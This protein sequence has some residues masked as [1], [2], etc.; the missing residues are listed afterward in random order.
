MSNHT[1]GERTDAYG[2]CRAFDSAAL[3]SSQRSRPEG[4]R[5]G[6]GFGQCG[7]CTVII[8]GAAV[9][10]CITPCSGVK[11]EITTLEGLADGG[12]LHPAAAGLDRRASAAVRVLP[13]RPD[14]VRESATRQES[15][16]D[17]RADPRGDERDAMPLHD[18]LPRSARH[19]AGGGGDVRLRSARQGGVA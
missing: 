8:N 9:R 2:G 13:E 18:V 7:A 16:S 3:R 4:P 6:C 11:G 19:Q 5:F 12:K 1:E 17:R 14:S 10:S 15:Q